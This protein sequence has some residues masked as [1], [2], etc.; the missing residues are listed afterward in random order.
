MLAIAVLLFRNFCQTNEWISF[1]SLFPDLSTQF[2]GGGEAAA[3]VAE[4]EAWISRT[5]I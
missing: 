4:A 5:S 1:F 2:D 3:A